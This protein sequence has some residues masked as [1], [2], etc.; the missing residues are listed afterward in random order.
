MNGLHDLDG[1]IADTLRHGEQIEEHARQAVLQL[2][3]DALN[4]HG[5]TPAVAHGVLIGWVQIASLD[6]ERAEMA[7]GLRRMAAAIE[8]GITN[9]RT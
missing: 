7:E 9:K 8:A 6:R 1:M 5:L 2:A 3:V 4:S